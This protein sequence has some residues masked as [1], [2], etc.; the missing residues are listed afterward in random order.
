[1]ARCTVVDNAG[2]VKRGRYEAAG[3]VAG[4]AILA[5]HNMITVFGCGKTGRMT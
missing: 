3:V 2:V 1:M 4:T 5:G